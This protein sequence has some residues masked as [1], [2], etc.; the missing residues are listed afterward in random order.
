MNWRQVLGSVMTDEM[1]PRLTRASSATKGQKDQKDQ[2]SW[3][4]PAMHYNACP[5]MWTGPGPRVI[6]DRITLRSWRSCTMAGVL[7]VN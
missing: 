7:N 6:P 5:P 3:R 4:L 2:T 1:L